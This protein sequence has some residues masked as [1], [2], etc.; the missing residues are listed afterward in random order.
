MHDGY[1]AY[2]V[3]QGWQYNKNLKTL[4]GLLEEAIY[5][6]GG[7]AEGNHGD[8]SKVCLWTSSFESLSQEV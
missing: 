1:I 8:I 3:S 4:E 6:S 5:K 7:I 2:V